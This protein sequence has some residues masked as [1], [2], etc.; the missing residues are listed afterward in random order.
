MQIV[1]DDDVHHAE[2][3]R[4]VGLGL[5]GDPLVGDGSRGTQTRIYHDDLG[6]V[7][8]GLYEIA[9]L[10]GVG[11][12]HVA[13]P[14]HHHL[15]VHIVARVVGSAAL[16]EA[17]RHAHG[18]AVV[19]HDALDVEGGAAV[20]AGEARGRLPRELRQ[21]A[22]ERVEA[23]GLGTVLRLG[24]LHALGDLLDGLLPG[25]LLELAAAA[26]A[27]TLHG[28]HHADVLVVGA[29]AQTDGTQAAVGVVVAAGHLARGDSVDL[30]VLHAGAQVAAG[31]AVHRAAGALIGE[32]LLGVGH[33]AGLGQ[34]VLLGGSARRTAHSRST[35][36]RRDGQPARALHEGAAGELP[37]MHELGGGQLVLLFHSPPLFS[38]RYGGKAPDRESIGRGTWQLLPNI[39]RKEIPVL[40]RRTWPRVR[41]QAR[42]R[43]G[44][45]NKGGRKHK[46]RDRSRAARER[47]PFG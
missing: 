12:G 10:G 26:L 30:V 40:G 41:D 13:A 6:A 23:A 4:R 38:P 7:L 2:G 9:E 11:V 27:G 24:G 3:Q 5:D 32:A 19:A 15:R 44:L 1:R 28:V 36:G 35:H 39:G 43:Q 14:E 17:E 34:L 37:V 33:R 29:G 21:I 47:G 20:G 31:G 46:R 42:Q 18:G 22:R 25:D 16:A 45:E 8:A